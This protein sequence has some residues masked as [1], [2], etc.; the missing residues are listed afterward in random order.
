MRKDSAERLS[1]N[2][3]FEGYAVDL[4]YEI[5]KILG[6][7]YTIRLVP[8][9]RY[10]SYNKETGEWDGMVR[11]LLEHRADLA[12]GDLT[13]TYERE[14]VVD[15]TMPFM[16][17]RIGVLYRKPMVMPPG[18]FYFLLPLSAKVWISIAAAY[19]GVSALLF[20]L[21]R[22]TSPHKEGTQL[23]LIDCMWLAFPS[24]TTYGC[25]MLPK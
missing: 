12:V 9:G 6:F 7:N 18:L 5:S 20:I 2:D 19:L 11:E 13:I 10:G 1:G 15:F 22:F 4:I 8:D 3:Q 23:T 24:T 21:A 25:N 14:Q 17:Y 16:N